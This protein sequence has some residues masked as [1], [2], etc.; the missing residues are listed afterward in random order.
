[1]NSVMSLTCST[2]TSQ[3]TRLQVLMSMK[4]LSS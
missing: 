1:M 3:A 2:I 4:S